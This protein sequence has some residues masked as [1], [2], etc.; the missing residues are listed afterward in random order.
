MNLFHEEIQQMEIEHCLTRM[1]M[2]LEMSPEMK[3]IKQIQ[4]ALT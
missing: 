2:L 3:K 4:K 1:F